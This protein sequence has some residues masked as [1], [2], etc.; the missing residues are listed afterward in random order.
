MILKLWRALRAPAPRKVVS[1]LPIDA[2]PGHW[3][4]LYDD[5]TVETK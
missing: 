5:G 2:W 4:V 1:A 3:N